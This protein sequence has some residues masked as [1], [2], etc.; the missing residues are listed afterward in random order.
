MRFTIDV[1]DRVAFVPGWALCVAFGV[2]I[3]WCCWRAPWVKR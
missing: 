2:L 1:F 3:A